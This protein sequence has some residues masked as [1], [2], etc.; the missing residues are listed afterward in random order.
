MRKER[1]KG[2]INTFKHSHKKRTDSLEG[3]LYEATFAAELEF[4]KV[5]APRLLQNLSNVN[6]KCPVR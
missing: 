4:P 5:L 6:I 2:Y 1:R 3:S